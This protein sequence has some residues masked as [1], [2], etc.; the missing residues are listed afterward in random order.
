MQ[1]FSKYDQAPEPYPAAQEELNI[2]HPVKETRVH[3]PLDQ[4]SLGLLKLD[5][6]GITKII[7]KSCKARTCP[8]QVKSTG[9]YYSSLQS[10]AMHIH[11]GASGS[12]SK[13]DWVPAFRCS[14]FATC[15][16]LLSASQYS[17]VSQPR[18]EKHALE[19]LDGTFFRP[20]PG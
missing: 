13:P 10:S 4:Q 16:S 18:T 6:E 2:S 1:L 11:T 17:L 19:L 3:L 12:V 20:D 5:L 15:C 14:T 8:N 9:M 7:A